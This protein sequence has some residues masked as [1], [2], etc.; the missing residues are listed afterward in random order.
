[1]LIDLIEAFLM[2]LIDIADM[3]GHNVKAVSRGERS[4]SEGKVYWD[5]LENNHGAFNLA[6]C[7]DHGAML[8]VNEDCTIWRC[9]A[10]GAGAFLVKG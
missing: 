4:V 10:C 1:M 6:T 8:A 5:H 9:I 2:K 7:V 3:V